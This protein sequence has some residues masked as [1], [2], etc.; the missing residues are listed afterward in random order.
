MN[1][2]D[3]IDDARYY[4]AAWEGAVW[5]AEEAEAKLAALRASAPR[6]APDARLRELASIAAS[7]AHYTRMGYYAVGDKD[8]H[9]HGFTACPH[10][11]C[12]LVRA[13]APRSGTF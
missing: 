4:K 5:R 11:D 10:P 13:S 12:K 6:Q 1:D 9:E 8:G 2:Q 7:Q 3:E